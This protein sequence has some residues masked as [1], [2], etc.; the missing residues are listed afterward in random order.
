MSE[1]ENKAIIGAMAS[2]AEAR[3]S[4]GTIFDPTTSTITNVAT[5]AVAINSARTTAAQVAATT[6]QAADLSIA[7]IRHEEGLIAGRGRNAAGFYDPPSSSY[8]VDL[9]DPTGNTFRDPTTGRKF[10]QTDGRITP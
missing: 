4:G 7:E 5:D 8:V 1:A 9:T 2:N 10:N 3:A 6:R